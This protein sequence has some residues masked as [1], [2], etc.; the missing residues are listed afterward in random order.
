MPSHAY[1][2]SWMNVDITLSMQSTAEDITHASWKVNS[3]D[4]VFLA[5]AALNLK[6]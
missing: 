6:T 4:A 2:M 5:S 3:L 1:G